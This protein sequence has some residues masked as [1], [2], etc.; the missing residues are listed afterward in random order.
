MWPPLSSARSYCVI[1]SAENGSF[2][3]PVVVEVA[4][5]FCPA[6]RLVTC[7]PTVPTADTKTSAASVHR[8]PIILSDSASYLTCKS[9]SAIVWL[10]ECHCNTEYLQL[11]SH[12]R[13]S[14]KVGNRTEERCRAAL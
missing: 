1:T 2:L 3:T 8:I 14:T 5:G 7:A 9:L 12:C 4:P 6:Y 13:K 11:T 10:I